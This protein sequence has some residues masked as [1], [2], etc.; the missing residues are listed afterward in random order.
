M[1]I[2]CM[3]VVRFLVGLLL[4]LWV[5]GVALWIQ[6]ADVLLWRGSCVAPTITDSAQGVC[7]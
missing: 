4:V 3:G 1:L 5:P 6:S 7:V 2:S